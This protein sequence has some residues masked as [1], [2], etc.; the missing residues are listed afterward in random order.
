MKISPLPALAA[1]IV[2]CGLFMLGHWQLN[3]A[4]QKRQMLAAFDTAAH[5]SAVSVGQ[6]GDHWSDWQY[7][8]VIVQGRFD[9]NHQFLLDNQVRH[10][11]VGF[12]VLTPMHTQDVRAAVLVDR[13]FLAAD[14]RQK[15]PQIQQEC[16]QQQLTATVYRPLGDGLRLGSMEDPAQHN[17]PQIVEFTD[18]EALS[19]QLGYPIA[20]VILRLAPDQSCGFL[21]EWDITA[22]F[23]PIRHIAYAVQWF[24]LA[25]TVAI[26]FFVLSVRKVKP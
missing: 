24:A 9:L 2:F 8:K 21:R 26:I 12:D 15:L 22:G 19:Q 13:G 18:F 4:E 23:P 10:G 14:R 1:L 17:W 3:R 5:A 25:A 11:Q 6:I 7:R 20:P 16:P